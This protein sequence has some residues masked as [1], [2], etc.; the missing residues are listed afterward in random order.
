MP[1]PRRLR[2]ALEELDPARHYSACR[3]EETGDPADCTCPEILVDAYE[4]EMDA[5]V[6]RLRERDWRDD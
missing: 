1:Y 3:A 2:Q 5:R 4:A 6:D